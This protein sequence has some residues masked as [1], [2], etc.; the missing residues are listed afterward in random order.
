[1]HCQET[2]GFDEKSA[3]IRDE[4][5]KLFGNV[6]VRALAS[7][8]AP[9]SNHPNSCLKVPCAPGIFPLQGNVRKQLI[10]SVYVDKNFRDIFKYLC[11]CS[12]WVKNQHSISEEDDGLTAQVTGP[13]GS[14]KHN[15]SFVCILLLKFKVYLDICF[16]A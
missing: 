5:A 7:Q 6:Q 12:G 1:M 14:G 16:I 8:E 13:P 11:I 9:L 2:D 3:K 4:L 10:S 15:L